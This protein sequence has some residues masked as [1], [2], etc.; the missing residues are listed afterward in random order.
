MNSGT[1]VIRNAGGFIDPAVGTEG[2]RD[3]LQMYYCFTDDTVQVFSKIEDHLGQAT[4]AVQVNLTDL[5]RLA[6]VQR[7]ERVMSC[8]YEQ[9]PVLVIVA[10][11]SEQ[12]HVVFWFDIRSESLNLVALEEPLAGQICAFHV[13]HSPM[14]V[15]AGELK[16]DQALRHIL[17]FGMHD[18]SIRIVM[19]EYPI[20]DRIQTTSTLVSASELDGSPVTALTLIPPAKNKPWRAHSSYDPRLVV[21]TIKGLLVHLTVHRSGSITVNTPH[22]LRANIAYN[23][24]PITH[25]TGLRDPKRQSKCVIAVGQDSSLG[26]TANDSVKNQACVNV[27]EYYGNNQRKCIFVLR[28][29]ALQDI[30]EIMSLRLMPNSTGYSI[31]IGFRSINADSLNMVSYNIFKEE[32][33]VIAR[34]NLDTKEEELGWLW[35]VY[36]LENKYLALAENSLFR[37]RTKI[38]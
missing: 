22:R 14:I 24:H 10:A 26:S 19:I 23:S 6:P 35:D 31:T 5:G 30:C 33:T 12:L 21:G 34:L 20:G 32:H 4:L 3:D 27:I 28:P 18:G 17:A 2:A 16:K 1:E 37:K 36:P 25:I 13:M 9:K 29:I 38:V 7:V 11:S 8:E 15:F